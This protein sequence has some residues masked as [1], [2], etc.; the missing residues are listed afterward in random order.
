[1]Q[2]LPLRATEDFLEI[3]TQRDGQGLELWISFFEIYGGKLFDL[4]HNRK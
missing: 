2:P 3:L 1:M 4:L